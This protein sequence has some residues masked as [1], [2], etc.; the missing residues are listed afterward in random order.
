[1]NS[2]FKFY[3]KKTLVL[4]FIGIALA[5]LFTYTGYSNYVNNLQYTDGADVWS[6]ASFVDDYASSCF[7]INTILVLFLICTEIKKQEFS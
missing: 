2:L 6:I 4:L 7:I 1:M 3:S 5:L